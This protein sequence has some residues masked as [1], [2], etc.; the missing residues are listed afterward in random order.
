MTIVDLRHHGAQ[1]GTSQPVNPDMYASI[2]LPRTR[3]RS[4]GLC[5][6]LGG[7]PPSIDPDIEAGIAALTENMREIH[8]ENT[9]AYERRLTMLTTSTDLLAF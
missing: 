3:A 4:Y 9:V 5:R 7:V 2:P 8:R 6:C 1:R